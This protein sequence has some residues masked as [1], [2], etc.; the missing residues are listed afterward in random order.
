MKADDKFVTMITLGLAHERGN[1][2]V[3]AIN[4]S[5]NFESLPLDVIAGALDTYMR[6]IGDLLD[7]YEPQLWAQMQ[8]ELSPEHH[9]MN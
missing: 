8:G 4:I 3:A 6:L 2:L 7:K 9:R 5:E 1:E